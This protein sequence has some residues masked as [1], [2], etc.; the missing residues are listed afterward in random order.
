MLKNLLSNFDTTGC[1]IS[2]RY[3]RITQEPYVDQV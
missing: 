1:V 3:T 2:D